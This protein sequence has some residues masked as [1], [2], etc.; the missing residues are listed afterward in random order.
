MLDGDLWLFSTI[1]SHLFRLTM[2]AESL[3]KLISKISDEDAGKSI[4]KSTCWTI[5]CNMSDFIE[6]F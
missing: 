1:S 4:N 3:D 6:R 5:G 2:F